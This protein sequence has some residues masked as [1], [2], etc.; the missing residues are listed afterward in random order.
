MIDANILNKHSHSSSIC[1]ANSWIDNYNITD[2]TLVDN[3]S[4]QFQPL[5]FTIQHCF[6]YIKHV[7]RALQNGYQQQIMLPPS[8]F[9][10]RTNNTSII[11]WAR[12]DGYQQLIMLPPSV[13]LYSIRRWVS[14]LN[15]LPVSLFDNLV[16]GHYLDSVR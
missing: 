2:N 1:D 5:R 13:Y 7:N 14:H 15:M 12:I 4:P 9:T 6:N 11:L 16:I 3:S 10:F 8:V